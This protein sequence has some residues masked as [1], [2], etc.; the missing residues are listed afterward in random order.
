MR[1]FKNDDLARVAWGDEAYARIPKS[2]FAY[3]AWHLANGCS[4]S[5]DMPGAAIARFLE[6]WE[7]LT[8]H[9]MPKVSPIVRAALAKAE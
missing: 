9:G 1:G 4:E 6:E 8:A 2:A 5:A 3:I 7:A